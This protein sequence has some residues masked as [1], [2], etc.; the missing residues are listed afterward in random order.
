MA[1]KRMILEEI[2]EPNQ[3]VPGSPDNPVKLGERQK[4]V[5]IRLHQDEKNG[6]ASQNGTNNNWRHEIFREQEVKDHLLFLGL[7]EETPLRTPAEVKKIDAETSK[8]KNQLK[9]AVAADK[10]GDV[11]VLIE[12]IRNQKYEKSYKVWRLTDAGR[13]LLLKGKVTISL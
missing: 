11:S 13:K 7:V 8:L 9:A 6:F 1:R 2:E 12:K 5:L 10:L 3:L 4:N